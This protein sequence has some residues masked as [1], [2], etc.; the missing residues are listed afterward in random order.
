[1]AASWSSTA[2]PIALCPACGYPTLDAKLC[3]VC[4]PLAA[5]LGFVAGHP[6]VIAAAG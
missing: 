3:S 4:S 1:M 6:P 2:R 5:S